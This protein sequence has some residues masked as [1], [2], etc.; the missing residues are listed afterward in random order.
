MSRERFN[1]LKGMLAQQTD[2]L[3][4]DDVQPEQVVVERIV[5]VEKEVYI[6][7]Y[8]DRLVEI[9]GIRP[10]PF[11]PRRVIPSDYRD[12]IVPDAIPAWYD[13]L[14]AECGDLIDS[15][16]GGE[17]P[18]LR[19]EDYSP[20]ALVLLDLVSLAAS[21]YFEGLVNPITV[22]KDDDWYVIETGERRWVAYHWLVNWFTDHERPLEDDERD[23]RYIPVR[24]VEQVDIWRQASENTARQNL[25]AIAKARQFAILIMSMYE[26]QPFQ[27]FEAFGHE[28]RYYAQAAYL[29]SV[30]Y[31]RR[32]QLL[33][34][35]GFQSPAELTRCRQLLTLPDSVWE[36]ADDRSVP[37]TVLMTC[38]KKSEADAIKIV[39]T[40]NGFS[41]KSETHGKKLRSTWVEKTTTYT[42]QLE[43]SL[44][45]SKA[46]A[47]ERRQIAQMLRDAAERI[48]KG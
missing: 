42:T 20:E 39:S 40:W 44:I 12:S 45:R 5:E 47:G 1:P 33:A 19:R 9:D 2:E 37:Q 43:A 29:D 24:E 3:L 26:K 35:M 31:G 23:F 8:T 34:A 4:N 30:P 13:D 17:E 27:P 41:Q 14:K 11:Q 21:I 28:R 7:V 18:E 15:L 32:D 25:N 10:T 6:P 22:Y 48:E 38:L 16:M 36:I 46:K